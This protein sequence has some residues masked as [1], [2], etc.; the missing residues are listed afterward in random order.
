VKL[1]LQIQLLPS[2]EQRPMIMATMHRFNAAAT[3]AAR[4][5]FDAGKFSQPSIHKMCYADLRSRFGIS[6]QMAV[7]AIAKA[8]ECFGR[9]KTRCPV[10]KPHGAMTYD[11]RFM[12]FKGPA[13]V[14]LLTV[15]GR[16]LIPMVYGEY[17]RERLD[18]LKGQ[19]DL[20]FRAGKFFLLAGIDM[21]G[22]SAID[23]K[24]FIGI[25][26]GVAKLVTTSDGQHVSGE[27]VEAVRVKYY[28][29]RRS[30][31]RKMGSRKRRA[32]KNARRA[33]KRIGNKEA[34][35]RRHH[36]HVISKTLVLS[37][38]DT[39]R[40]I[41]LENLTHIRDR[42]RFRKQQRAKMG[43]WAFA[44]LRQFLA[45]K[46]KLHGVPIVAVNPRNTSR[47]C[48]R[49]GHCDKANRK[50][51]SAFLC[52]Q[53]GHSANADHNAA[54]NIAARAAV[55]QPQVSEKRQHRLAS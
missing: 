35:F 17:Q 36:N 38:K 39:A 30:L 24:E 53:C 5:G 8:V 51:Q 16:Q 42:T 15:E 13:I 52:L 10:F 6:S 40:G 3:H 11:E 43:G 20:I 2:A 34:R 44:Q 31:G 48:N 45:Y 46:G 18:Q 12:S 22:K 9:D 33:M 27:H 32:R 50:S 7:R 28:G 25:D 54:L 37:A 23:V 21:P 19:C 41:A 1:S 14:S 26:L 55:N 29:V 4:V 47:T 49:C